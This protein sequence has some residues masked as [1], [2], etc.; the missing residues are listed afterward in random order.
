MVITV[1]KQ[2][3]QY[4]M[5]TNNHLSKRLQAGT[6]S[7]YLWWAMSSYLEWQEEL[8]AHLICSFLLEHRPTKY[9]EMNRYSQIHVLYYPIYS[10][11]QDRILEIHLKTFSWNPS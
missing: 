8:L 4:S 6:L 2:F 5:G 9:S 11:L 1:R 10:L 3:E 7:S